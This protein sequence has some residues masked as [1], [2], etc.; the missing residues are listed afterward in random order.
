LVEGL[1]EQRVVMGSSRSHSVL[2]G[3]YYRG[4]VDLTVLAGG[5]EYEARR[6]VEGPQTPF[7]L[8]VPDKP[9]EVSLNKNGETLALD[10]IVNKSWD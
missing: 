4:V 6:V 1:I 5:E 7:K 2:D 9:V 3:K 8:K 10:T